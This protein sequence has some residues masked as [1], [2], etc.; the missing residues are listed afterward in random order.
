MILGMLGLL[1][2]SIRHL[3]SVKAG[4]VTKLCKEKTWVL[5][6]I[7]SV[8]SINGV[9]FDVSKDLK[10]FVFGNSM[11]NYNIFNGQCIYVKEMSEEEKS[12]IKR[13][14]VLVFHIVDGIKGDAKYKLRKFVGYVAN[15]NFKE[16]YQAHQDRIKVPVETFIEQCTPKYN[17]LRE[18]Y[19]EKF[20]LSETY[21]EDKDEVL[22][23]LH[24]VSTIFGKVEYA[25]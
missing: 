15:D 9:K 11:K 19:S 1:F 23:S 3:P 24:P 17:K 14:P 10:M 2:S 21:D 25:M 5:G 18:K 8:V 12:E 16:L 6:T 4:K 7:P 20:V 13:F 22:Y